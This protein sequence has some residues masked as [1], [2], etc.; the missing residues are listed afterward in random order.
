M[1]TIAGILFG[2]Y[3]SGPIG[4]FDVICLGTIGFFAHYYGN[5]LNE[6]V[7]RDLDATVPE[8]K[9]KPLVANSITL[10][11]AQLLTIISFSSVMVLTLLFYPMLL[12]IT[13]GFASLSMVTFYNM[14]GKYLPWAYD[15]ALPIGIGLSVLYGASAV[16]GITPLAVNVALITVWAGAFMEW[17]GAM[18][19]VETDRR[20]HVPTRAVIWGY[21][22]DKLLTLRDE[23]IIFGIGLKGILLISCSLPVVFDLVSR[24]YLYIFL[25]IGVPSQ[26]YIIFEMFGVHDRES[27]IRM[28]VKSETATLFLV[29]CI[30]LENIYLIGFVTLFLVSIFWFVA[31]NRLIYRSTMIPTA[32]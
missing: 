2:A 28:A 20:L 8:L 12:T 31:V 21:H 5:A 14:K 9:K 16:H 19:D 7:D 3:A 30:L 1:L 22:H 13:L 4:F 29:G 26:L 23:N 6:I 25:I 10:R 18:K 11:E 32:V 24:E 17:E 15:F 27:Y